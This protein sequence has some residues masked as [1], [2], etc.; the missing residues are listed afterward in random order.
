MRS[1]VKIVNH[2]ANVIVLVSSKRDDDVRVH[3]WQAKAYHCLRRLNF[4]GITSTLPV[5]NH[6]HAGQNIC[7]TKS[8][9]YLTWSEADNKGWFITH[10]R[11]GCRI[12]SRDVNSLHE[13]CT[14]ASEVY[15]DDSLAATLA[16]ERYRLN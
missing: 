15:K 4:I 12:Y 10:G 14:I 8:V 1:Q 11:N 9:V 5:D 2:P 16:Y 13:L 3:Q 7:P 6:N